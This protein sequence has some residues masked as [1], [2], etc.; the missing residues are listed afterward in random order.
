MANDSA[1]DLYLDDVRRIRALDD[2]RRIRALKVGTAETSFYP[3]IGPAI[4]TLLNAVGHTLKPRVFC[5]HHPSGAAGIADFGLFEQAQFRRDE[6]PAWTGTV[7]P[8][9]DV[10]EAK[11]AAHDIG[12]LLKGK[13]VREQ[14]CRLTASC[15]QPTSG[16]SGRSARTAPWSRASILRRTRLL[17]GRSPT[18]HA[19]T[20]CAGGSRHSC[21]AA[22]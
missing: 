5:L 8:E 21:S 3:A 4:G 14:Y 9:R 20:R 6:A 1:L 17:L 16:S 11:G 13:Q 10:V 2:V 15:W 18:D 22:R 19:G 12:A 7:V